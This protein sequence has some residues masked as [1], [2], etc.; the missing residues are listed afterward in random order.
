MKRKPAFYSS[1]KK[2][3]NTKKQTEKEFQKIFFIYLIN[4]KRFFYYYGHCIKKT[5][6]KVDIMPFYVVFK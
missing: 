6:K 4:I 2:G 5:N 3:A 1:R